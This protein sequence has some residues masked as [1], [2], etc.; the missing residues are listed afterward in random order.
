MAVGMQ[1]MAERNALVRKMPAVETLGSV[2]TICSD[3][4]GTLTEGVMQV[5]VMWSPQL[6]LTVLTG[7]G[8]N[9]K[10]GT[11]K[12]LL[13]PS[14]AKSALAHPPTDTTSTATLPPMHQWILAASDLCNNSSVV[15]RDN[16][17]HG[18]GDSTEVALHVAAS[19]ANMQW[20]RE[21]VTRV[22]ELAFDSDRKRMS[23]ICQVNTGVSVDSLPLFKADPASTHLVLAKGAPEVLVPLCSTVL[24]ADGSLQPIQPSDLAQIDSACDEFSS[25]GL[26]TLAFAVRFCSAAE[27]ANESGTDESGYAKKVE[28]GLCFV[29]LAALADPPRPQIGESVLNCHTAGIR[30]CMITGD[31]LKTAISIARMINL[32]PA[33]AE[34]HGPELSADELEARGSAINGRTLSGLT[35]EQLAALDPFPVVFAR[36]SPD[37]KLKIVKALQQRGNVVAMTGDGVNDAPAIRQADAGIAMG[38]SGTDITRQAADI[39]LADDNFNTIV[40]AVESGRRILDNI[41]KFIIYLL[42]CNFSEVIL[43][44]ISV[45][46]GLEAPLTSIQILYANIVVDIPPSLALGMESV[47]KD[48]MTRAPRD[49]KQ[50]VLTLPYALALILQATSMAAWTIIAYAISL[51]ALNQSARY[52][53]TVAFAVLFTVQIAHA[54]HCRSL[55]RSMFKGNFIE[56]FTENRWLVAGCSISILAVVLGIYVPGWN[57]LFELEPLDGIEWVKV[58]CAV[59]FHSCV[60]EF[61]KFLIRRYERNARHKMREEIKVAN[62]PAPF[63][64]IEMQPIS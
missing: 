53:E 16:K 33:C 21:K 38:I 41:I 54:F 52:A 37:D 40:V 22:N 48:V 28:T 25:L 58:F 61:G 35:V 3:K 39:V 23:V 62:T 59:I 2:T 8:L 34:H 45:A 47:E 9:P 57:D 6:P 20:I 24:R 13:T 14:T 43:M 55:R 64:K 36:V 5:R 30:V 11:A 46:V 10:E 49:P 32:F 56:V 19:R 42:S 29:G 51:K 1:R 4:T 7:S 12:H 18:V 50:A 17:W 60:V 31:H 27:V 44:L 26:R 63:I 15:H